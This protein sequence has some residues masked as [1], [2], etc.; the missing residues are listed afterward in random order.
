VRAEP[1]T[2]RAIV[3][4]C[5]DPVAFLKCLLG[6]LK[7]LWQS[8]VPKRG[9][10]QQASVLFVVFESLVAQFATDWAFTFDLS[11]VKV[12]FERFFNVKFVSVPADSHLCHIVY[13]QVVFDE[14]FVA[15]LLDQI[16]L[17]KVVHHEWE[18]IV[19][20]VAAELFK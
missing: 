1:P 6:V 8:Q 2:P 9:Q 14:H 3:L 19:L 13:R 5:T 18:V 16:L 11:K 17:E 7:A 20:K 15:K 4:I 10:G 12:D